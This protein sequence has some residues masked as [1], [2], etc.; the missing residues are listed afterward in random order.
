MKRIGRPSKALEPFCVCGHLAF[1]HENECCRC[2]NFVAKTAE[3][4]WR[5]PPGPG[6][7]TVAPCPCPI[8]AADVREY[9][10]REREAHGQL[11]AEIETRKYV[12]AA[13]KQQFADRAEAQFK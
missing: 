5:V 3:N 11:V 2:S 1:Q 10:A 8:C 9:L 12:I 13:Q 7:A 6:H 4:S